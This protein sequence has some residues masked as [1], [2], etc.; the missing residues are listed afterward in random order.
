MTL[1]DP[2]S[3][4]L[5][6]TH[7]VIVAG[8]VLIYTTYKFFWGFYLSP[9][10]NVP[11]PRLAAL[12]WWYEF[13]YDVILGGQYVFKII[14]LHKKYG[15][16][17]R[18]NPEEV[19]VGDPNFHSTLYNRNKRRDRWAFQAEQFLADGSVEGTIGHDLHKHRRTALDRFFSTQGVRKLQEV[20]EERIDALL[21]RLHEHARKSPKQDMD[22][23]Y[24]FSAFTSDVIREYS[25]AKSDHLVEALD[26]GKAVTDSLLMGTHMGKPFQ[27]MPLLPKLVMALPDSLSAALFPGFDEFIKLSKAIHK[28]ID[29]I[30]TSQGTSKWQRD[31]SHPTILHDLI[32]SPNLTLSEKTTDRLAQEGRVLVQAG[33]LTTSWVLSLATFYLLDQPSVLR[34]LRD[35]LFAHIPDAADRG[36]DGKSPFQLADLEKLPYLRAVVL[37]SLRF[38][39]GSSSRL[40]RLCPDETLTYTDPSNQKTHRFPPNTPLSMTAYKT[41]MDPDLFPEPLVFRPERYLTSA[42]NSE[43]LVRELETKYLS[44]LWGGGRTTCLGMPL[45]QAELFLGLSKMWRVWGA[46]GVDEREG[47]VG[48]VKLAEG[49]EA[50][51]ARMAA[52]YW[53]PIP[54]KGT[55][56]IRVYFEAK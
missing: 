22:V 16:V 47:D 18:I 42:T 37:E 41:I 8:L 52:D 31:T 36:K 28:Q 24:P 2:N 43:S 11:G 5:S 34:Q 53:I 56:G 32:Q 54:W 27:H 44:Q 49:V 6:A 9:I 38:S 13:Y 21:N 46:R 45:A 12:T 7:L 39:V 29:E 10:A 48:C 19:H 26:Y 40:I 20:I 1:F 33:T 3:F 51:D 35:E 23:M 14:E 50:R 15:P 4:P 30:R 55:K 25:F 17:V